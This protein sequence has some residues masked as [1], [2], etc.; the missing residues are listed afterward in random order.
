MRASPCEN[1]LMLRVY[2]ED[3]R[4]YVASASEQCGG[5]MVFTGGVPLYFGR[6][7]GDAGAVDNGRGVAQPGSAHAWGACGRRFKSGHPDQQ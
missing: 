5:D 4:S 6:V 2:F 1:L 3:R 7:R